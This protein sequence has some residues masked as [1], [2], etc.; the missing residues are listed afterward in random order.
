MKLLLMSVCICSCYSCNDN[1]DHL[2]KEELGIPPPTKESVVYVSDLTQQGFEIYLTQDFKTSHLLTWGGFNLTPDWSPDKRWIA[3]ERG[4]GTGNLQVWKMKFNGDGKKA[5]TSP[6]VQSEQ[7][8]WSP[9]GTR[10]VLFQLLGDRREIFIIDTVGTILQQVTTAATVPFWSKAVFAFPDWSPDGNSIV[11]AF[12]RTDT[13]GENSSLGIISLRTGG[14]R[15]LSPLDSLQPYWPRWSPKRDEIVFV[16][17]PPSSTKG[18]QIFRANIDGTNPL[19]LTHTFLARDPD[20]SSDGE[21]IIYAAKNSS[22]A[23]FSIWVITRDGA[24][25]RKLLFSPTFVNALPNW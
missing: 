3:Y 10:I 21:Q 8:R 16:G 13:P 2:T 1:L 15:A 11:F 12:H 4:V 9:D 7:P 5:L 14:F 20:W 22:D 24:S 19:Q 17:R 25:P 18:P 23:P 6:E